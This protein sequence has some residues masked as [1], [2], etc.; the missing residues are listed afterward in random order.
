[1]R[2]GV[3]EMMDAQQLKPGNPQWV[4]EKPIIALSDAGIDKNLA[5]LARKLQALPK[6][7]F[8]RVIAEGRE[9]IER[10]V[11]RQVLKAVEICCGSGGTRV[12]APITFPLRVMSDGNE[13]RATKTGRRAVPFCGLPF[14]I[15]DAPTCTT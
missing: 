6:E 14:L 7:E 9:A 12:R 5:N 10:G 2:P 13:A 4:S 11:E 3:G 15:P 1:V 8:E